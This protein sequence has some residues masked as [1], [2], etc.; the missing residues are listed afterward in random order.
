MELLHSR[1]AGLDV[2]KKS[3]VACVRE[4][5]EGTATI[6]TRTFETM[7]GDL[8]ALS[9]WLTERQVTVV[10]ME[11]TG[12]YWKPVWHVLEGHFELILANASHVKNVPGRKTD[13]QD[14]QWLAELVAHGLIRA[15]F[16]PPQP[17]QE[18]REL[19]R[20][21]KQVIREIGQHTQRVQ[22]VLE[23]G[24]I[25]IDSVVSDLLGVSG[26]AILR[27]MI[28]GEKDAKVL[29]GLA[30]GRLQNRQA[31]L[32]RALVGRI[33][34]HHRFLLRLHMQMIEALEGQVASL[35]QRIGEQ[36][37]PFR[38]A[39]ALL[40]EIPGVS[41]V[42][43]HVIVSEVGTDMR[44]FPS[45]AHFLSW[46][47]LCPRNDESA[48]KRRST[49]IRKGAPWLKATLIQAAW[50]A[51]RSKETYYHAQFLRLR[52]RRGPKKAVVAVAASMM[53]AVYYMLLNGTAFTDLGPNHFLKTE[54]TKTVK[55]LV[56]RLE[57]MGFQ[58]EIKE[59]A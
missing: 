18:M 39:V 5:V 36:V 20:T 6:E 49:K 13:V 21:R 35:D 33:T 10:A 53:T 22:K 24:N 50:A 51:C 27:A 43:A 34:D 37:D 40:D 46:C 52:S 11:A 48:G 23:D 1:C 44:R 59:A 57:S 3:V 17:I 58:V 12:V 4:V 14:A 2:H 28:A 55:R 56:T 31:E 30:R 26:R 9:D 45:I 8:L 42:T 41:E 15:S 32:E 54:K 38:W 19:T 16:V 7:T 29:A 25:K 47:G